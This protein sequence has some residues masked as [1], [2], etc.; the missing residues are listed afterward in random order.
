MARVSSVS[1][2]RGFDVSNQIREIVFNILATE[3]RYIERRSYIAHVTYFCYIIVLFVV[4]LAFIAFARRTYRKLAHDICT[5]LDLRKDL[6]LLLRELHHRVKNSLQTVSS[7]LNLQSNR[8]AEPAVAIALSSA[9][10]RVQAI[11]RVHQSLYEL[12]KLEL[13]ALDYVDKLL[14]EM[15]GTAP[16]T[17]MRCLEPVTLNL[18][19]AVPLSLILNELIT[20]AVKYGGRRPRINVALHPHET[21]PDHFVLM[22][23]DNGGGYPD[24]FNPKRAKS[25]GY[26]IIRALAI[27][28]AAVETVYSNTPG[29]TFY[30]VAPNTQKL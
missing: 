7:V 21:I 26:S 10:N 11:A 13:P 18:D 28:L 2:Q 20:N 14:D 19:A 4:S 16:M 8:A 30:M 15:E 6:Q 1:P 5:E 3:Q 12:K 24:D 17:I 29:A 9:Q 22:V 25:L 23:S 27:Q